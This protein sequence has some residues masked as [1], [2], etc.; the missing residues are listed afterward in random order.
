[1]RG[2]RGRFSK[3]EPPPVINSETGQTVLPFFKRLQKIAKEDWGPRYTLYLYRKEPITDRLRSGDFKYLRVY[4][5][6]I[7]EDQIMVEFGSGKY[8]G[9]LNCKKPGEELGDEQDS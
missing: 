4:S 2:R 9:T 3:K 5:E 1:K 6:P 7:T 8:K